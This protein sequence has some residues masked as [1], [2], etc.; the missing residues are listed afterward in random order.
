M[1]MKRSLG[2]LPAE[3]DLNLGETYMPYQ[4]EC[5][6]TFQSPGKRWTRKELLSV[7]G[8]TVTLKSE[9]DAMIICKIVSRDPEQPY[10]LQQHEFDAPYINVVEGGQTSN[11]KSLAEA[12][13]AIDQDDYYNPDGTRK[14]DEEIYG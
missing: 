13:K 3:L 2:R 11:A 5:T 1:K 10:I 9:D 8:W 14:T 12:I 4:I 7:D 6:Q